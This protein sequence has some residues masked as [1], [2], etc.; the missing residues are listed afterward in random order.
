[1]ILDYYGLREQPFGATPDS[2]YLFQSETHREALGS[3]LYGIEQG[4]GFIG[5]IA[6]PGM[7]KTTLLFRGLSQLEY[8]P[9]L[10]CEFELRNVP[11]RP[12]SGPKISHSFREVA[13]HPSS[14]FPGTS[15]CRECCLTY[16]RRSNS[17]KPRIHG[18]VIF[19]GRMSERCLSYLKGVWS[20]RASR[21]CQFNAALAAP[22]DVSFFEAVHS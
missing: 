16:R 18:G 9:C 15:S 12:R 13:R 3:I 7:G 8:P 5:L 2:R 11:H 17:G 19:G 4:R 6:K 22:V 21:L 20:S 14:A 1:M 10:R